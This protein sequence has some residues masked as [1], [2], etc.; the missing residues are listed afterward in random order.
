MSIVVVVTPTA[1]AGTATFAEK[2]L[3]KIGRIAA[4]ETVDSDDQELV[5]DAYTS[6][7]EELRS[8]HL[9]DWGSSESVPNWAM[10]HVRDIVAN[11]IA[12]DYGIPRSVDEEELAFRRMAKHLASDASGTPI[13]ADYY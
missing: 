9:V 12:N 3:Q 11:R 1:P 6:V 7:Y 5:D 10:L 2:V 4:G 13:E 8:R